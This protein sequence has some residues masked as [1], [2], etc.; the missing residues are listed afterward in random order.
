MIV[1]D[2]NVVSEMMRASP[3]EAVVAWMA[4]QPARSLYITS[5]VVAE[6]SHGILLLPAGRR[7][8]AIQAAADAM[9]QVEFAERILVFDAPAAQ[10]YARIAAGR[11]RAG[12]PMSAFDAQIAAMA[13]CARASLATRNVPDFEG[14]GVALVDPWAGG[15]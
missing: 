1:L 5:I 9:F 11:R 15:T 6:I 7:R 10:A 3:S 4:R 14:C 8:N 2:T 12:R 13:L